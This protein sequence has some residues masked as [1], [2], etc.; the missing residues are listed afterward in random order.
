MIKLTDRFE[1]NTSGEGCTLTFREKRL[2]PEVIEKKKTGKMVEYIHQQDYHML[3]VGQC[4][5]RY[6]QL[7]LE[8][9]TDVK[10]C[11]AKMEEVE[12]IIKAIKL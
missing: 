5:N 4:L 2:K 8:D 1:I 3:T 7:E 6:M 9:T 11:L 12:K 10:Y